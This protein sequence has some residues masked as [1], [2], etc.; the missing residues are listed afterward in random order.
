MILTHGWHT[1]HISTV[2]YTRGGASYMLG[3]L[4]VSAIFHMRGGGSK[5]L[6]VYNNR[7][8]YSPHAWGWLSSIEF[9]WRR[10]LFPTHMWG[11][12]FLAMYSFVIV[13]IPHTRGNESPIKLDT[14]PTRVGVTRS[15]LWCVALQDKGHIRQWAI[16]VKL[17]WFQGLWDQISGWG[18][19]RDAHQWRWDV[20][21]E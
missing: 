11:W 10:F 3:C 13:S 20:R 7:I 8:N 2:P 14:R 1:E 17:L 15:T 18:R 9:M 12:L 6:G 5:L 19:V 21:Q 4:R 16:Y